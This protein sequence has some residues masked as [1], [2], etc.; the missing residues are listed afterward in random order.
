MS[1]EKRKIYFG[2]QFLNIKAIMTKLSI[3]V[4]FYSLFLLSC[5]NNERQSENSL[6]ADTTTTAGPD[7]SDTLAQ[8]GYLKIDK[9]SVTLLPF[10]I[11]VVL[12]PRAKNK[13]I[14]SKETI[15]VSV[16]LTGTPKDSTL[17]AEDGQFYVAT[18]EKEISYGQP[19]KFDNIK[20]SRKT[21]DQLTD[22]DVYVTAFV[23]SG[24]KSSPDNLLNCSIV[25]GELSKVVNKKQTITGNL[26]YGDE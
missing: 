17:L 10:E 25:A 8:A 23:Y 21:F 6:P 3:P 26:I 13:I 24:R 11:D 19:A 2:R 22:K 18:L 4:L 1:Y 20:F 7:N 14:N 5:S 16:S 12:N 15:I 9:D